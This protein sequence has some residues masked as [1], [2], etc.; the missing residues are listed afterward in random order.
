MCYPVN[1]LS[2]RSAFIYQLI[3]FGILPGATDQKGAY[4]YTPYA[5]F[6]DG[7]DL[8]PD[9]VL[10]QKLSTIQQ[11]PKASKYLATADALTARLS[12]AALKAGTQT[13]HR[14][15]KLSLQI[16]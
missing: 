4:G 7:I 13:K 8:E 11:A 15:D 10:E 2:F 5:L 1:P 3:R 6:D 16:F 9:S 12:I 14:C